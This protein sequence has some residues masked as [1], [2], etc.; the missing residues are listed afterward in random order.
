[1]KKSQSG[2]AAVTQAT[3]ANSEESEEP[4][5]PSAVTLAH[6]EFSRKHTP[7][8]R[9]TFPHKDFPEVEFWRSIP[10]YRGVDTETFLDH[11]WQNKNAVTNLERL[12]SA[13]GDDLPETFYADVARGL[14]R[15]P[16]SVRIPPY[17]I[18][19]IDWKDPENDPLRRQY[20]PID[21]GLLADHP[22]LT[23][24]SLGEQNDAKAPGLTHRY[25]DKALF[26]A[27]KTCPL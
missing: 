1:M 21:S 15:V 18:A 27:L 6:T 26:L 7:E 17:I 3:A 11:R 9:S 23:L 13:V 19:L 22:R 2:P 24:D 12:R 5:G 14:D 8:S 10:G 16:M 4:P 25:H 20:L